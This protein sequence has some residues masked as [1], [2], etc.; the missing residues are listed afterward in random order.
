MSDVFDIP[1]REI[2][3]VRVFV[4]DLPDDMD[5]QAFLADG[6]GDWGP[7]TALNVTAGGVPFAGIDRS[8]MDVVDP[9][10]L[11]ELGLSGLLTEGYGI[12][13]VEIAPLRT[14]LDAIRDHVLIVGSRAFAGQAVKAEPR[15]P[16]RWIATLRQ[17]PARGTMEQLHVA[18]AEGQ[19]SAGGAA[20]PVKP[21]LPLVLKLTLVLMAVAVI[22]AAFL[23]VSGAG[24]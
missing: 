23:G 4:I 20:D 13:E 16:L 7:M 19:A 11:D 2:E 12:A 22:A 18:S 6:A 21:A 1:A 5:R 8:H 10:E 3:V 24:E 17:E 15:A 14:Q 9:R